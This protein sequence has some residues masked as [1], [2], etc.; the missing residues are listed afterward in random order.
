MLAKCVKIMKHKFTLQEKEAKLRLS[1]LNGAAAPNRQCV[2]EDSPRS[3]DDRLRQVLNLLRNPQRPSTNMLFF[4]MYDIS[5]NKVR[6]LVAK[7]LIRKGC[8]R[9]QR[10]VFLADR[11]LAVFEQIRNDLAEVQAAYE[12]EDS[13]FVI[14]VPDSTLSSMRVIGRNVDV[15]LIT[16]TKNT[17]FV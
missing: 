8:T 15:D 13:I 11:P 17:V 14:P 3:L 10:S 6:C 16:G 1:V 12:N 5:D 4:I 2:E 7:Y 9:V